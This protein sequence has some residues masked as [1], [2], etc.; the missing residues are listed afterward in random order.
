MSDITVEDRYLKTVSFS[1]GLERELND[2]VHHNR[3]KVL[4]KHIRF[5]VL[6]LLYKGI[7]FLRNEFSIF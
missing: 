3:F 6:N 1:K 2:T 4:Q 7:T 5:H